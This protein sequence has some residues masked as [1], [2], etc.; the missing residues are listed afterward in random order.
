MNSNMDRVTCA[1]LWKRQTQKQCE[2]LNGIP[3]WG[4]TIPFSLP[5]LKRVMSLVKGGRR[6]WIEIIL[7]VCGLQG[8]M[9]DNIENNILNST[10]YV[11][12][13]VTD[14]AKAVV[15]SSKA[16]KVKCSH[17]KWSFEMIFCL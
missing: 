3:S 10:N 17:L 2:R 15:S 9:I 4:E 5:R 12:K 1:Y 6:S 13:A 16:R 11:E 14:T 7:I 8:E